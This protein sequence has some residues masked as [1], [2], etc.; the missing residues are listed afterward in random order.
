MEC[1]SLRSNR[2]PKFQGKTPR[3]AFQVFVVWS[4]TGH[5][6]D[7]H[8]EMSKMTFAVAKPGRYDV[9]MIESSIKTVSGNGAARRFHA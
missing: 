4:K 2:Q 3:C 9:P 1:H 7:R 8:S 6:K 5:E